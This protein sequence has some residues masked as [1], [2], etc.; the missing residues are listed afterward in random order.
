MINNIQCAKVTFALDYVPHQPHP[1]I[2][3]LD[4]TT[5]QLSCGIISLHKSKHSS[6]MEIFGNMSPEQHKKEA[7]NEYNDEEVQLLCSKQFN[8]G[9]RVIYYTVDSAGVVCMHCH[10]SWVIE[11]NVESSDAI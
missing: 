11:E 3:D 4:I 9:G 10:D 5:G 7:P 2:Y 6:R 1:L 8:S